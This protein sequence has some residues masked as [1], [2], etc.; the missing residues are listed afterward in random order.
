MYRTELE[1][2]SQAI[3]AVYDMA[4]DSAQWPALMALEPAAIAIDGIAPPAVEA[5]LRPHIERAREL[6][7]H[8]AGL[9][10]D[11]LLQEAAL[12]AIS[13]GVLITDAMARPLHTTRVAAQLLGE[14]EGVLLRDGRLETSLRPLTQKLCS[15]IERVATGAATDTSAGQRYL[16]IP[17]P[18]GGLMQ[19]YIAPLPPGVKELGLGENCALVY[20]HDTRTPHRPLAEALEHLFQLTRAESQV[21][22][23]LLRG[24]SLK[25]HAEDRQ[26]SIHTVKNQ[27]KSIFEKTGHTSQIDFVHGVLSNPLVIVASLFASV[28]IIPMSAFA[29]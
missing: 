21:A 17:L 22:E 25:S 11:Q 6:R 23:A 16:S 27:L 24:A 7:G 20:C 13:V 15:R 9:R 3:A 29:E 10:L 26:L 2:L 4:S 1:S 28:P 12:N 18:D 14:G 8:L 19:L 5:L